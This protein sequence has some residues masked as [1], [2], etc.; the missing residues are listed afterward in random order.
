MAEIDLC[1]LFASLDCSS[2][3]ALAGGLWRFLLER[4]FQMSKS[5]S[6]VF[7]DR[8]GTINVDTGYP[9]DP[10]A[11]ELIPGVG[12]AIACLDSLGYRIVIV[13]NQAAIGRGL[14]SEGQVRA[15]NQALLERLCEA[16]PG[17]KVE[18][19][20]YC[21]HRPD[22]GCLCRK[23]QIGMIQQMLDRGDFDA[24]QSWVV[25][26]KL[27]DILF[28]RNAGI[29]SAHQLLVLT[30]HGESELARAEEKPEFNGLL[31]FAT[32]NEAARWIADRFPV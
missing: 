24:E 11:L 25:G 31:H 23:P 30:G 15:F 26:D 2:P 5:L 22:D 8:D 3:A 7:L 17:A 28:G 4:S 19:I 9:S 20:L 12:D 16:N 18:Q 32:I 14:A 1:C 13:S 29:P 27:S 6:V 21:P 10:G